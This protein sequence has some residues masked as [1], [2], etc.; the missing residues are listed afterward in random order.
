MKRITGIS[1]EFID[2]GQQRYSTV[3]D[4]RYEGTDDNALLVI[5]VSK[6]PN[7]IHEQLVAIHEL[8]EAI[9][10]NLD[11]VTQEQV[12]KFDMEF[13]KNRAP[14]DESEP[15]DS[16]RAPYQQQHRYGDVIERLMCAAARI[17]WAVY[18]EA[19][20]KLFEK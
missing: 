9:L 1:I 4:W 2:H 8:A 11:G 14:G 5:N 3:G 16:P 13:E 6:M 19:I 20:N 17:P 10:C 18:E 7:Q 15:G 12:D